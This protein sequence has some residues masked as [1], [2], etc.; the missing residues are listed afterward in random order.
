MS[1]KKLCLSLFALILASFGNLPWIA[2]AQEF[3]A[4]KTIRIIVGFP[5]GGG[6][7]T[8]SRVIG[9]HIG[10]YIP[11]NPAVVVD[12]V[13]GAGSLVAA[14]MTYKA[15]KPDGLTIG[16]FIGNLV[17]QQLFGSPGVEFDGR[18]FEWLGVPTRDHV[19]CAL[20]KA[21]GIT[22]MD[23]WMAAKAPVKLG[24]SAPGTTNDDS[25]KLLKTALGL[26]IQL[27]S[28]YKGTAPIKLAAESGEI[29]GSCW[30]WESIK[31][32]WRQGLD[33]G[34]VGIVLQAVPKA[35]PDL[36]KVPVAIELAKSDEARK[37]IDIGIHSTAAITRPYAL[38]PNT[39]KD[40]VQ[41]L[42]RAFHETLKDKDFLAEA[43]KSKLDVDPVS[44]EE[45]E[46]IVASLFKLDQ[47]TIT[48][49][50]EILK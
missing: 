19:V 3:Y 12:N 48:K 5:A 8:Y 41:L 45:V 39:P 27:V 40:R 6:F 22:S 1:S 26:P 32:M 31:V 14:N 29:D 16:N 2:H 21:S 47:A 35:V 34:Q 36:A 23:A 15:A 30:A 33:A 38:P 10:K 37:L 11:G 9:R 50:A 20:T 4:G 13:A 43:A 18:K 46:K 42:R 25:A 44:G 28:G 49:M 7:D 17:S 24:G